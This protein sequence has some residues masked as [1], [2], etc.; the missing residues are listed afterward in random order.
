MF[1]FDP[2]VGT[3]AFI[4]RA[5]LAELTFR[6]ADSAADKGDDK[7]ADAFWALGVQVAS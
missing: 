1:T 6:V 4:R 7:T 5:M 3:G 2:S